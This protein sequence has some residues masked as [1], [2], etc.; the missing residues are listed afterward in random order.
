M[1]KQYF[2]Q[3]YGCEMN[4]HESEKIAGILEK[5]GYQPCGYADEADFVVIN[6]CCIRESSED[7]VFEMLDHISQIKQ[8]YVPLKVA[9][10]GCLTQQEGKA[11]EVLKK[12]PFIDYILGTHNI[13]ELDRLL[14]EDAKQQSIIEK[15][16]GYI[17]ENVPISRG[18]FPTA[19]VN[20]IYG[21][22]NFC[23]Y[24][25]VP[26]VRGRERSRTMESVLNEVKELAAAG[27]KE[28]ILLGQ[29]VNSYGKDLKDGTSFAKLLTAVNAIPG[30]F[31]VKFTSSHPKDFTEDVIDA[32]AQGGKIIPYIHL[33]VQSGS[34]KILAA[35]NRKYTREQYIDLVKRI[36]DK[37]PHAYITTDIIVGFNGETEE[38]FRDTISL[39]NECN[40]ANAFCFAY[41]KRKG[42]AG[43]DMEGEVPEDIKQARLGYISSLFYPNVMT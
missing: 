32:V 35:M 10:C 15:T 6:T 42:T 4:A 31:V 25:I 9:V 36:R 30:D 22:N 43:W 41:S 7:L 24:C 40:F 29:N 39:V 23:S 17:N 8:Y 3:T 19:W 11:E 34:N 27:Y 37:I 2:I 1:N 5:H 26:Y 18:T 38:D 13:S 16:D 20:I 21:C 12:Y 14:K 28:I 33:P